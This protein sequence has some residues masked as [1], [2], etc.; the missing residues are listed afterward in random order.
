MPWR[1]PAGARERNAALAGPWGHD[2][3]LHG[4]DVSVLRPGLGVRLPLLV[5]LLDP[6]LLRLHDLAHGLRRRHG[7]AHVRHGGALLRLRLLCYRLLFARHDL[8]CSSRRYQRA[9]HPRHG[10][11]V[12]ALRLLPSVALHLWSG[13]RHLRLWQQRAA[14]VRHLEVFLLVAGLGGHQGASHPR[15]LGAGVSVVVGHLSRLRFADCG[16]HGQ[17]GGRDWREC[18][19][20]CGWGRT[21][22]GQVCKL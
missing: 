10:D 9:P 21:S 11:A 1:R 3:L 14:H 13:V 5:P 15:E 2:L 19:K 4:R 8:V 6:L 7:R 20:T 17:F 22:V 18:G 12:A 16:T